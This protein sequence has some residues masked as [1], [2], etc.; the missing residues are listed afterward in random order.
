MSSLAFDKKIQPM[1]MDDEGNTLDH[2]SH[3]T[4]VR[5]QA[6]FYFQQLRLLETQNAA[7]KFL[8]KRVDLVEWEREENERKTGIW[9][10]KESGHHNDFP[11]AH[12]HVGDGIWPVHKGS[13]E[14]CDVCNP[15][16]DEGEEQSGEPV[17]AESDFIFK[18]EVCHHEG[19]DV[20]EPDMIPMSP[21]HKGKY[22][23]CDCSL[24]NPQP[25]KSDGGAEKDV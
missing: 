18:G 1:I 17:L 11:E 8:C 22:A 20:H 4:E 24:P 19:V 14:S 12:V 23:D 7:L 15:K 5:I 2:I 10:P 3:E 21:L 13:I 16:G 25:R 6:E 9:I